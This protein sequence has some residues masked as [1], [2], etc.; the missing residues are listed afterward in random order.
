MEKFESIKYIN[1]LN[2]VYTKEKEICPDD[3]SKIS[4]NCEKKNYFDDTIPKEEK[5]G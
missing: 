4:T 1:I 3:I 2:L 5:E